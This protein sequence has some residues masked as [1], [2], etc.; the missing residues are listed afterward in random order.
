VKNTFQGLLISVLVVG[1]I[2]SLIHRSWRMALV[3]V[4]PNLLPIVLIGGLM[5]LLGIELKSSTSIIFSIAFGIATD[6]TIHF[7]GRLK[8]ERLKGKSL[9]YAVKRTF[10]STGKAV[11][12]TSLILSAGFMT[13]I[14][15]GFESTFLFG[16][17]V[18]ITLLIAVVTDLLLFPLLVTWLIRDKPVT[19]LPRD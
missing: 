8:L 13:L 3:A 9:L 6:D 18:S 4:I 16:L 14:S 19:S 1:L 5:G 12:V 10:I 11:V 17:L 15:S 2:I 7:L